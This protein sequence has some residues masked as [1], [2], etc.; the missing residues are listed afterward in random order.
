MYK[1]FL[2]ILVLFNSVIANQN[3][4][5]KVLN[6]KRTVFPALVH[7]QPVKEF[8]SS[9][10]KQ[11]VQV[12]GSGVIIS[13]DGY[14]VTNN[15]VAEKANFVKCT[16][17]SKQEV[18][19]K[20]IGLDPWT[21][22]AVLKLDLEEAGI[23]SVPF[24]KFG[25][26]DEIE[27][28]QM[29]IALGSPLGL[30]RSL[31]LGVVSSVDRYFNDVGEMIS[32]FN[33]WIQTDAAIN[34]GNSGGPLVNL[35]GDIIGINA[36]AVV[37]GENLG[38]AIPANIVKHVVDQIIE[39]GEVERSQIGIDWQEI[40]EYRAFIKNPNLEGVLVG[41]VEKGSAAEHAGLKA[42]DVVTKINDNAVSAV[43]LEELPKIRLLI[44][45]LPVD[46]PIIFDLLREDE[47]KRIEVVSTRQGKF[48]GNE[49]N[50]EEW[51]ISVQEITPRIVK[52][53]QLESD[54]G[55]LISG[56]KPGS[57]GAKANI[58]P[59]E[60]LLTIDD[61]EIENLDDFKT[62]YEKYK[63]DV[64]KSYLLFLKTGQSNHFALIERE[65]K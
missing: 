43:H 58:Y 14:V 54:K 29:V 55:V 65:K 57:K 28:G 1:L 41:G 16:L 47:D 50:C 30:A 45:N 23:E 18:Q 11:K 5:Q 32:P 51:G 8:L 10:E 44:S 26:S 53:F 17:S 2:A 40:K 15:H 52:N 33:L 24:A 20:V 37:F 36:R 63:T 42:G 39:K 34:P 27:V 46:S 7:I 64:E 12:T 25:D 19:A 21:D 35:D 22:L 56:A 3:S 9:G 38:F 48:R 49:F 62:K 61:E 59:G 13:N 31:S 6:A 4:Q 60:I